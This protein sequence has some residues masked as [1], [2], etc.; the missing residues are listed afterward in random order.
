M[1]DADILEQPQPVSRG[2]GRPKKRVEQERKRRRRRSDLTIGR[3]L[4]L[5]LDTTQLDQDYEYRWVN[6]RPG[7]VHALTMQD[8]WD[9]VTREEIGEADGSSDLNK[10]S[11]TGVERVVS[12]ID[13]MRAVL[14]RKPKEYYQE[15]KG[16]EQ[17]A[18]DELEESMRRGAAKDEAGNQTPAVENAYTPA[19]GGISISKG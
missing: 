4:K 17:A 2:P 3:N 8:D 19:G 13:G 16:K 7:R 12:E 6:D 11:G 1:S 14:L 10:G 18:I 5:G 9:V 15:D